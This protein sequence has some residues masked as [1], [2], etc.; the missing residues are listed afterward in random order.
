MKV[1][2]VD[3]LR[4]AMYHAAFEED[5]DLQKWDGGCW[6]RYKMFENVL[7]SITTMDLPDTEVDKLT[8]VEQQMFLAA[9]AREKN[10]CMKIEKLWDDLYLSSDDDIDLIEACEVIERKVK[11]G[12]VYGGLRC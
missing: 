4:A 3:E 11:K 12:I 2:H 7:D 9:M 8:D 6:I 1:V 5:S 10:F